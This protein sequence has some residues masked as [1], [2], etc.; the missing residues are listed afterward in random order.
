MKKFKFLL[1]CISC[2]LVATAVDDDGAVV[3]YKNRNVNE[4]D[5]EYRK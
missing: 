5:K 3:E 4:N 1:I 2:C